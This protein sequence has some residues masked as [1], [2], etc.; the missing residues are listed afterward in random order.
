MAS[1]SER[2]AA[3]LLF[4][5]YI[6]RIEAGEEVDFEVLCTGHPDATD[7]L[8]VLKRNWEQLHDV[9]E[10]LAVSGSL[11][12]RIREKYGDADPGVSLPEEEPGA[13]FTSEVVERLGQ[14][15]GAFGRYEL[16]GEMARG[17]QGAILRVW[18][19]DLRRHLA[20]KVVLGQGDAEPGGDTPRVDSKTLGRFLEEAQVTGQL[21]HPG[22]VPVHELG[23]DSQGDV[24][25]TMKLVRGEDLRSVFEKV[26]DGSEGW[27]RTR[28]LN[29]LSRVCEAISYAHAKGVVHRDLKPS[30]VMVGRFGEVYVMDWG[31]ARVMG[32]EDV[33]DVRIRPPAMTSDLR[34]ER[35]DLGNEPDSP[36]VT[37]DGDVV[38]T[39]AYMPPEQA[40][41]RL[42]E[43]GP[44]SDVYAIGA[45]LYHLLADRPPYLTSVGV[46]NN[47]A[48]WRWVQEG[49]PVA[50]DRLDTDAPP[51]LIAIC[52]KAMERDWRRRYPETGSLAADLSAFLE[53][54][55]VAAYESGAWAEARKW[56]ARNR[57]LA[58]AL[59]AAV[60][61]LAGGLAASLL[62]KAR[63]DERA[64]DVLRLSALQDLED[65]VS[66]AEAL[67][68]AHPVNIP[69]YQEW[70]LEAERLIAELPM[71]RAKLSTLRDDP[72]PE[73]ATSWWRSQLGKLVQELEA[74][75]SGLLS[76]DGVAAG[77]GWS[78][79]RRLAFAERLTASSAGA[80]RQRWERAANEVQSDP[81]YADLRLEPQVGLAPIGPDPDTGL[82]EF[83]HVASGDEP[84][85]A[86][87]GRLVPDEDAGL[88]LVLIPGAGRDPFF[89]SKYELTQGQWLR[90]T[91]TNPSGFQAL[92]AG[93]TLLHPVEH[94][95]WEESA[96]TLWNM[97]LRLPTE[98]EWETAARAG[99]ASAWWTGSTPE[100]LR[101]HDAANLGFYEDG[102]E[103]HAP[104]GSF[105][106]NP[107][108]LHDVHG[109]VFE[110][111]RDAYR[112]DGDELVAIPEGV[113]P[114]PGTVVLHVCRGGSFQSKAEKA[115]FAT[116]ERAVPSY[117]GGNLG[118]RPARSVRAGG[119]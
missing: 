52:E 55:V 32:R 31:L 24:Y 29:V 42:K 54:R 16:K 61:L 105:A 71:H 33:K 56:I 88:V 99:T 86:D 6:Q 51:E 70:I 44:H 39:P 107:W 113:Q 35:K 64:S 38:G 100:T 30:N 101:Q 76:Q 50:L 72:S 79:R 20:M 106:P 41:G 90:F 80:W 1:S 109:N 36:L 47:Y 77:S 112:E 110:W 10:A 78:I 95:S 69:R 66:E 53:R 28:A 82:Q 97:D 119:Y 67:W 104:V 81:R 8:R 9:L 111:C 18:D 14:R 19:E 115:T 57:P 85:R 5:D 45:M 74:L 7:E 60:L 25:F 62:F 48:V 37:M 11:R 68:P 103:F 49:P 117:H 118:L 43:L 89:L 26:R 93:A 46:A 96:R 17:G 92:N 65:L 59:L 87:G 58:A 40:A 21:D 102:F 13:D 83:L 84:R 12:H 73:P 63:A 108:G 2:D 94:V 91:A 15:T 116:R 4:A 114:P 22:I 98:D 23:L 3:T 27:T 34:S 75:E